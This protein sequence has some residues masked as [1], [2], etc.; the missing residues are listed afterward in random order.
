MSL[1][2]LETD[3]QFWKVNVQRFDI[4]T[5]CLLGV[6]AAGNALHEV[7]SDAKVLFDN[8]KVSEES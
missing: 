4:P 7:T 6:V 3:L 1:K 5:D 8:L 2:Q